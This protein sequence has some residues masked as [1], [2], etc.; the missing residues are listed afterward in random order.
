VWNATTGALV[1]R[2]SIPGGKAESVAWSPSGQ[3]LAGGSDNGTVQVWSVITG[4]PVL[5]YHQQ[6][7]T[8]WS[9]A[10]SPNGQHLA[11]GNNDDTVSIWQAA[12]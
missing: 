3:L 11:S 6:K 8:I 7:S 2:H 9:L 5:S 12:G 4:Q 10:W 1:A